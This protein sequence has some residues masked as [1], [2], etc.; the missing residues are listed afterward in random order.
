MLLAS[1]NLMTVMNPRKPTLSWILFHGSYAHFVSHG[2]PLHIYQVAVTKPR[3]VLKRCVISA[4]NGKALF[5]NPKRL[6]CD[7][8][9]GAYQKFHVTSFPTTDTV[10]LRVALTSTFI[11]GLCIVFNFGF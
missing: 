2:Q 11:P 6:H 1:L 8:S 5:W 7:F 9:S 3:V 4:S 10:V